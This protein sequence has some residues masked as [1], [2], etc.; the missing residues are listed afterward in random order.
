MCL[1]L[2]LG[3]S[4]TEASRLRDT[5]GSKASTQRLHFVPSGLTFV[6]F[7]SQLGSSIL[8]QRLLV[9]KDNVPS[10]TLRIM[11]MGQFL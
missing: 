6:W 4:P 2:S 11:T 5:G 9:I 7:T 8:A 3:L 10:R 1:S